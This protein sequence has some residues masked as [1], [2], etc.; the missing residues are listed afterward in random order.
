MGSNEHDTGLTDKRKG[1]L[2]RTTSK[3]NS[4][5]N[6]RANSPLPIISNDEAWNCFMCKVSFSTRMTNYLNVSDAGNT[7]VLIVS[8]NQLLAINFKG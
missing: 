4:R 7:S 3:N 2:N 5:N 6:S 1:R 8:K